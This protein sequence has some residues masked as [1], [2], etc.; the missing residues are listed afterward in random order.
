MEAWAGPYF[1][2]R[3]WGKILPCLFP[4]LWLPAVSSIP[5]LVDAFLQSL[6]LVTWYFPCVC[7]HAVFLPTDADVCLY[8][9]FLLL[10][11]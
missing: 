1:L 5:W 2:W 7:L 8:L 4:A 6:P 3:L 10:L 9:N 11:F